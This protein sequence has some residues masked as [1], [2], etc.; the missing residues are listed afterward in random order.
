M[1]PKNQLPLSLAIRIGAQR[2]P[3]VIRSMAEYIERSPHCTMSGSCALGAAYEEGFPIYSID[4]TW[5]C[6]HPVTNINSFVDIT[7]T[8]LNDNFKWSREQIAAW[9]ESIGL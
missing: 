3:Q 2:R 1:K 9:L 8:S 4:H 6:I 5:K 7:I